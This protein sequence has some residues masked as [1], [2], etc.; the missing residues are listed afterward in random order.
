MPIVYQLCSSFWN[1]TVE[2][3]QALS[4]ALCRGCGAMVERTMSFERGAIIGP[5]LRLRRMIAT[6]GMGSV[7]EADHLG[8]K[9]RVA[10]K[11]IADVLSVDPTVQKRF[12]LEAEAAAQ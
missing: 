10:V 12:A 8:L 1:E 4:D 2:R 6:G 5:N 11:L 3:N 9:A 7:W